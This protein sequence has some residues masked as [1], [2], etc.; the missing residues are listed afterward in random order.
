MPL[1]NGTITTLQNL[2]TCYLDYGDGVANIED[3]ACWSWA[4]AG[5]INGVVVNPNELITAINQGDQNYINA[6]N[7]PQRGYVQ[8]LFD[9]I[10][11]NMAYDT[12]AEFH[13]ALLET[14]VRCQGMT[15]AGAGTT[16]FEICMKYELTTGLD[17]THWGIN[18]Y[19]HA[20]ETTPGCE[21]DL[22]RD[23]FQGIWHNPEHRHWVVRVNVQSLLAA[24]ET[25]INDIIGTIT[26]VALNRHCNHNCP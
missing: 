20:L 15:I 23:S 14:L 25:I 18:A 5:S 12:H 16:N 2:N 8:T 17:W 21:I 13:Q 3:Q 19:G 7:N 9:D 10:V 1:N 22:H 4:L 11:V 6:L 26:P 24:H